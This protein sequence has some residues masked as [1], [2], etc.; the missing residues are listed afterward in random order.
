MRKEVVAAVL[1]AFLVVSPAMAF[2]RDHQYEQPTVPDLSH[3][4]SVPL[5][6]AILWA[7]VLCVRPEAADCMW[8]C[9]AWR[10]VEAHVSAG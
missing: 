7:C 8:F 10:W 9:W 3:I 5:Q 2:A 1:V 4:E 6:R